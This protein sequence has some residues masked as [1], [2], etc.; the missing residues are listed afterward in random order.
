MLGVLV[1][2]GCSV[3]C[4]QHP[5][6]TLHVVVFRLLVMPFWGTSRLP[7]HSWM[8]VLK[9]IRQARKWSCSLII[10]LL[11][12]LPIKQSSLAVL[13]WKLCVLFPACVEVCRTF[14]NIM[15]P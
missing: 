10:S 15:C 12:L 3:S 2:F 14:W 8:Q 13:W 5:S 9:C 6:I 7:R 1:L 4:L 11:T